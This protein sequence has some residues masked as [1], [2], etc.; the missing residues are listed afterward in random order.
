MEFLQT[1][2]TIRAEEASVQRLFGGDGQAVRRHARRGSPRYMSALVEAAALVA[3]VYD[4]RRPVH[5]LREAL[6]TSDFPQ[7]FG[8]ILDRQLLANYQAAPNTWQNYCKRGT[9]RDFRTVKRFRVDGAEAVLDIVAEQAPYPERAVTDAEYSYAVAKRGA[10]IPFSF[11]AMVNDDLDALKDIP[12]RFGKAARRSEEKF[13]T[14]LFV[15]TTGPHATMYSV[16]N[17]NIVTGNPAL[18]VAGLQT[19]FTV[20]GNMRDSDDE[21]IAIEA[22]ELVVPPALEVTAQNIL[23][24]TEI[25]ATTAGGATNQEM[26]FA[27]WMRSR[28]RLSVNPYI[29]IV[30][31]A[32]NGATSWFLFASPSNGRPALEMGFLRGYEEPQVFMKAGDVISVG[33]GAVD[34]MAGDFAND[35]INY[36]VRHIFGGT[37][38]D[39][40]MSV[41]SNGSGG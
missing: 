31:S 5:Y 28:M 7:L 22:V 38:L 3:D 33:G 26:H 17:A 35:S 36:K 30:A 39:P 16:G 14:E 10:R 13:A 4:G 19:A 24:A 21:P 9:V 27:N 29:P 1:L 40:K 41:A 37:R 12:Q 32:S 2:E 8:D 15:D 6:T 20:L 25:W 18:S 34:P 11:E 23:N